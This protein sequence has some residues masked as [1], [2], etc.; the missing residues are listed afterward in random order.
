MAKIRKLKNDVNYLVFEAVSDCNSYM[1][2]HP[3]NCDKTM[4][5]VIETV[6]L[7]NGLIQKINHPEE[8]TAAYF[9]NIRKELVD[10]VDSVFEKL[11]KLIK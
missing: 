8:V 6:D 10:G 9:K 11:R 1:T 2:L 7:R 4:D 5:L 3:E